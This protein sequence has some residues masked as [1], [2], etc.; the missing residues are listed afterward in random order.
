MSAWP[1]LR[2]WTVWALAFA[3]THNGVCGAVLTRLTYLY[4]GEK[5]NRYNI[6][7]QKLKN[8]ILFGPE[9][10]LF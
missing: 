4:P 1:E 10:E 8:G 7:L 2:W 6:M 9:L 5:T 3:Q